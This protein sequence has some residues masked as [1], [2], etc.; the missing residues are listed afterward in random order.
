MV[1]VCTHSAPCQ[2]PCASL[3]LCS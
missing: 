1:I 3:T 2:V